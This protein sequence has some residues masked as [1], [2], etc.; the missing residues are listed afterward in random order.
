MRRIPVRAHPGWFFAQRALEA[1]GGIVPSNDELKDELGEIL[2]GMIAYGDV[3]ELSE[4]IV[5]GQTRQGNVLFL[6]PPSFVIRPSGLTFLIGIAP[7][8]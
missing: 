4:S 8:D 5:P 1:L 7:F 3:F 2:E 6:R